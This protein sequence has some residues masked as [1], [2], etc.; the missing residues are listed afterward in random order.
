MAQCTEVLADAAGAV[1][2]KRAD[3]A[4]APALRAEADR[5]RAAAHPG[6]VQVVGSSGDED[7]WEL[8]LAHA[9]RPLDVVGPLPVRTVAGLVA[10]V[11]ATLADLHDTGLVHGRIDG[12]HV[13]LG[14]HGRP[15]LCG[16][17]P[18]SGD[19]TPADDVE[20]L[21][22]LLIDLLGSGAEMEPFPDRRWRPRRSWAGWER[23]ALLTLADQA[24]A[25]PP[26]RRP[27]ARRLAAALAEAVPD[28]G[29]P[30]PG[31]V[32]QA[33]DPIEALRSSATSAERAIGGTGRRLA[34]L[35]CAATGV[36]ALGV[37]AL[38]LAPS[39]P[40]ATSVRPSASSP[41]ATVP[42]TTTLDLP[43]TT[44]T[45]APPPPPC[46]RISERAV[47]CEPI[48]RI[49]GTVV[50]VGDRRYEVGQAGDVVVL[51]DWDC[52]G[53][54][55]PAVLRPP[56][57]EVFVFSSWASSTDVVIG[58]VA[59]VARAASLAVESRTG[60]CATLVVTTAAGA[61]IPIGAAA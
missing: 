24:C 49:D 21:G 36:V 20:A 54:A 9:G 60:A 27:T 16:F 12:S 53:G 28:A 44:T 19:H 3:R 17:G 51:G 46:V 7:A 52:D 23:R 56:T 61:R 6:V 4:G 1:V 48:V 26:S 14:G 32:A 18:D 37:G 38:R 2:V 33:D 41:T 30:V 11:A 47:G 43:P 50:V 13:L 55:T 29:S 59:R 22:S 40:A 8:R 34:G 15:V 5:L 39:T 58:P 10:A 45:T 31:P 35:A 42:S 25:E 57:G